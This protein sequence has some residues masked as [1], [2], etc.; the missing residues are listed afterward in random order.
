MTR[1]DWLEGV[2]LVGDL[3]RAARDV[4][5]AESALADAQARRRA[6]VVRAVEAGMPATKIAEVASINRSAVYQMRD[7]AG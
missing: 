1:R 5:A 7:A 6:A 2:E 3:S 4:Q